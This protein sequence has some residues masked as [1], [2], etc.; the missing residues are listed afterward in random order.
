MATVIEY[1]GKQF[2]FTFSM[3]ETEWIKGLAK[4]MGITPEAVIGAAMNKGLTYYVE[5]FAETKEVDRIKDIMDEQIETH[6]KSSKDEPPKR[7]IDDDASDDI[8]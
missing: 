5:T 3:P 6:D 1:D 2:L 8:C 4:G 7:D